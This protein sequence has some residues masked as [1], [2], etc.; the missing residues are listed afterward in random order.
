[1][2]LLAGCENLTVKLGGLASPVSGLSYLPQQQVDSERRAAE[3][4]PYVETAIEPFDARRCMFERLPV[5][6]GA[7]SD[8][9][10]WNASTRLARDAS[11]AERDALFSATARRVHRLEI[12]V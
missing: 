11:P 8:T 2:R 10:V 3:W 6:L 4:K 12:A 1:M 7:G 5:G 9:L